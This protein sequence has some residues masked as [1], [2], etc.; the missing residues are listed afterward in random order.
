MLQIQNIS[1]QYRTGS[2]IQKALDRV[3]LNLRDNEFVAILG[4]SGS[5]KTT[6]LNI[7]GGLDSYDSGDL[8]INGISTKQYKDRD[9]DSYRNHTI[10]FVFQ[11]YHL[12][13]H[14]SILSNVEIALTISGISGTERKQR[15]IKALK[16][17]GLES[18]MHKKPN[19]MSGGQ[20]QRVAIA[21]ALVND[22]AILL[23]DEPTGALDSETSVQVMDLLKEVAKDRLVVMV[24]H[25]PQLAE[26]YATRIVNLKDGQIL[27]DS[28][29]YQV[30]SLDHS[31]VHQN[32]GKASMS[33]LT[34][35]SLSFHNLLTK[36]A[37]TLLVAF[38]GSIGI[39]GIALIMAISNGVNQYIKD[40]EEKTLSQYPIEIVKQG[41]DLSSLIGET[42]T[43][44]SNQPNSKGV[45][46]RKIVSN[47]FSKISSNDLKSFK[48]HLESQS[49][50]LEKYANAIEYRFHLEPMIYQ[51]KNDTIHQVNPSQF[52][53]R[54]A[55]ANALMPS[56]MSNSAFHQM[57]ENKKLYQDAY[58][59]KAGRW[60]KHSHELVLVLSSN[61]TMSDLTS[62]ALGLRN[63]E[64]LKEMFKKFSQG[65]AVT[66]KEETAVYSYDQ[67]LKQKLK[68][69][70]AFSLYSYDE[71]LKSWSN[72]SDDPTYLK[73]VLNQ[74]PDLNI[75]GIVQPKGNQETTILSPGLNY[76]S[77]LT[78]ELIQ[79]AK[80]SKIVQAQLADKKTNIFTGK[81][82][83]EDK[84]PSF[85]MKSL[86]KIN[87]K[88]LQ[89]AFQINPN[90]LKL[91]LSNLQGVN[92][93]PAKVSAK[94]LQEI[95]SQIR[96][97]FSKIQ[98]ISLSK[99]LISDYLKQ[100][101]ESQ[102]ALKD[103]GSYLTSSEARR[104]V[105]QYLQQQYQNHPALSQ[106][107]TKMTNLYNTLMQEYIASLHGHL[108]ANQAEMMKGFVQYVKTHGQNRVNHLL[109]ESMRSLALSKTQIQGLLKVVEND[110]Q[111]YIQNHH[112]KEIALIRKNLA[113]YLNS[114]RGQAKI[115]SELSKQ[116][117]VKDWQ[118]QLSKAILKQLGKKGLGSSKV[119]EQLFSQ[120][121]SQMAIQMKRAVRFDPVAFSKAI[122]MNLDPQQ[123][124]NVFASMLNQ[125]NS[126]YEAN[127]KTLG[128]VD[129]E[130]PSEIVIYPKDFEA[131]NEI[132]AMIHRYN[133]DQRAAK[134]EDKVIRYT[135]L[136]GTLMSS[137]T[138]IVN[139]I[140]YV[141]IA[142]VAI[143]LMVSSIMIGVITFISVLERNK[144]IGILR[145]IGASKHNIS[146][147]FNAET[148][149]TGL[150]AGLIG[151]LVALLLQIPIN[152]AIHHLAGRT[153]IHAFLPV[154]TMIVLVA[155][156]V[157]LTILS[158]LFPARKAAKSDPVS[159][160]RSE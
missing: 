158:G 131:K 109:Q 137:V 115:M 16:K 19:Q 88:K 6:L 9:W 13:P 79:G 1:K 62:Y 90:A 69:L 82:F 84:K 40:T 44:S 100:Y 2:L 110:Y 128:Y 122:Q 4:P 151:V 103:L 86:F 80:H 58:E 32:M 21:R 26:Q 99:N 22:P 60:P 118:N 154:K 141:L 23:A 123:L 149:M 73:K 3:Y 87:P 71:T 15:A 145:A 112:K 135:D 97:D 138:N 34:A 83:G 120:I 148:F 102:R 64:E 98:F 117:D 101:P 93:N 59:L 81:A 50:E 33:F 48:N 8:M 12:I 144:E 57:P 113:A 127:L 47:M 72:H 107:Q 29:P 92:M 28:H 136:V 89:S 108:P 49:K 78:R 133:V 31:V 42:N 75:V 46:E 55:Y 111:N 105:Q 74:A 140:S 38:A 104:V 126:S 63:Y 156:S 30:S 70:P 66:S 139:V 77:S 134:Q 155:L 129:E 106:I 85:D 153:D 56:S 159:A 94:D 114:S 54:N 36:K 7:I 27:S 67:I 51:M 143:S 39:I 132:K 5:G 130:E 142:F 146:Q 68:V 10:G 157:F 52:S 45:K 20:M 35:L 150:L 116:M 121:M 43:S 11:S 91:D 61:G 147:V 96:W 18:Q 95:F 14:Q 124:K 76:P 125:K 65:E 24:T 160:L 17:V 119:M 25:N 53:N 41:I 37:R 152:Q